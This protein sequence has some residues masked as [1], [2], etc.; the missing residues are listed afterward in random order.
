MCS[1]FKDSH[2]FAA[3]RVVD[4]GIALKV[5]RSAAQRQNAN[6]RCVSSWPP[7]SNPTRQWKFPIC[8]AHIWDFP[9]PGWTTRG[10][11]LVSEMLLSMLVISDL[12]ALTLRAEDMLE[13][14]F[15]VVTDTIEKWLDKPPGRATPIRSVFELPAGFMRLASNFFKNLVRVKSCWCFAPSGLK[16]NIKSSPYESS[17]HPLHLR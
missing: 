14:G 7:Q 10:Q 8:F 16:K 17:S 11:K 1:K 2:F 15:L 5:W 6:R 4:A 12:T 13:T 9:L 3:R